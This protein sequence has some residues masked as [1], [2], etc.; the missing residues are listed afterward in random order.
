MA[1]KFNGTVQKIFVKGTPNKEI[2]HTMD[3]SLAFNAADIPATDRDSG[4]YE[5][6]IHGLRSYTAKA[7]G[8]TNYA[9][10]AGKTGIT[11]LADAYLNRTFL[12]IVFTTAL[13]GDISFEAQFM[14]TQFTPFSAAHEGEVTYSL[15][16]KGNGPITKAVVA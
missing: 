5:E 15:D 8:R 6:I 4:G 14:L 12:T 13:T 16:L 7:T 3:I 2:Q 9:T 11:E 1:G 10:A